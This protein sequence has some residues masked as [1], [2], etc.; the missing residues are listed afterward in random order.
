M[1]YAKKRRRRLWPIAVFFGLITA[2]FCLLIAETAPKYRAPSTQEELARIDLARDCV[3]LSPANAQVYPGRLYDSADFARGTATAGDPDAKYE[4]CR[5][6]LALKPGVTYGIAGNTATYAQRVYVNG[7]LLNETGTV[8]DAAADFVPKTDRY[9]AYFTPLRA[10][11]E[12]IVQHAW[13]NH[14]SGMFQKLLL[15]EQQVISRIE[16]AQTLC[17]GLITGTLLAMAV[18]F[19]GMF[20]FNLSNRSM[21]WFSL[22]CLCAAVNYLIYESKQIMALFPFLNW[23]AGHKIELLTNI[24]YFVFVILYAFSALRLR[25]KRPFIR[26]SLALLGVLTLF[27]I[28]APS[29]LYTKY[30]VPAGALM[31]LSELAAVAVLL[32]LCARNRAPVQIDHLILCG[33]PLLIL[34]VYVVE[35]ATYFSHILYLRAYAMIL[36][37]FANALVL[38]IAFSR[39]ERRLS[40]AQRREIDIAEENLM[41]ERLGSLKNDFMRNIAHEMKT[42]LTVMSGYAQLTQRQLQKNAVDSET[43]AN[44]STVAREAG[45]LSDMVTRL[46][47]VTCHSAGINAPTRFQPRALLEDAAAVCRPVLLKNGNQLQLICETD[48]EILASRESLLQVLINLAV[49]SNRHT[50]DG[51]ISFHAAN[52]AANLIFTVSDDGGG[53]SSEQL[54]HI[55]ERG[56]STDGGNGLGL[57][58][59]RDVIESMGGTIAVEETNECGTT[60]RFTVPLGREAVRT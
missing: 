18:F 3:C 58:I 17:D 15:A 16:R 46:L 42:P 4:T 29:T 32:R 22:S 30:L 26:M 36:L 53:I 27:Y 23:Y 2:L 39:T 19:S 40:E 37:A 59:C 13:F 60:I 31:L 7:A 21:L 34:A 47:D 51:L 43:I 10:E 57:T 48:R 1:N 28:V 56:Y 49:N 33:S 52:D 54:P 24:Y 12:I 44:L 6:V 14:Q 50:Q 8:S 25:P 35:G 41:L 20:L 9:I 38:T 11:T 45:R 55:F 5:V